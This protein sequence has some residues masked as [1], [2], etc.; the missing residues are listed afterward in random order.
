M[1]SK[2]FWPLHFWWR[3][4]GND[5]QTESRFKEGS[6]AQNMQPTETHNSDMNS[7]MSSY[8]HA[9]TLIAYPENHAQLSEHQFPDSEVDEP[10][11]LAVSAARHSRRGHVPRREQLLRV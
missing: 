7:V 11:Y 6:P 5:T 3:S 2:L 1:R 8:L 10:E 9:A 4:Y